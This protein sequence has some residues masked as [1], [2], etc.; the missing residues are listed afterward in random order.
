[1]H[2]NQRARCTD[3]C[4]QN[5]KPAWTV[6]VCPSWKLVPHIWQY[7]IRWNLFLSIPLT[8]VDRNHSTVGWSRYLCEITKIFITRAVNLIHSHVFLLLSFQE[9]EF[10]KNVFYFTSYIYIYIVHIEYIHMRYAVQNSISHILYF[11]VT[12]IFLD[13]F[14]NT[15]CIYCTEGF[16]KI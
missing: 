10:H 12:S 3:L 9:I 6:K 11:P 15:I 4:K 16:I 2:T 8:T 14:N 5:S 7:L 1:M 13:Y